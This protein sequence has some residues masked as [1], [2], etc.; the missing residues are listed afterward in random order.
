MTARILVVDDIAANLRLLEA[1]LAA[2]YYEVALAASGP[3]ALTMVNRWAPDVILLDVMMP[4]MDGYEVCRRLKATP[5]TSHIP[6]VMVTALVDAAERVRA[7]EA[8]ADDFLSKPVDDPTLFARLRALLRVKQVQDA[9]RLRAETA[10]ELGFEAASGPEPGVRG[11]TCLVLSSDQA[12]VDSVGRILGED[13]V[14]CTG[15]AALDQAWAALSGASF[16]LAVLGLSAEGTEMLRFASRLRA[17]ASTRDMPVLLVAEPS[18]RGLVL[19]GFDL[20]ANDHVLRPV[21]PN[22]LRARARNQIR[23][24][25]YQERLRAD[26]DRS[27]ELAVTDPLTGLRNRRYVVRHLEGVLRGGEAAVLM[28]DVDRF[29]SINDTHGHAAGDIALREVAERLKAHLRAADVVARYGGEEF[30]VV[31]AG[32]PAEYAGAV[33]ERLLNTLGQDSI[34]I[35]SLKLNITASIGLAVAPQGTSAA[36]ATA[37]ADFALYRAKAA[38]RNRVEMARPED[39]AIASDEIQ[40]G[41]TPAVD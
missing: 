3:E 17:H 4:G 16:D 6:V 36:V 2:E 41:T 29:K 37:A 31:L 20:G 32:A 26:L 14:V 33:A 24:K 40:V 28:L 18:Q 13:G 25:H 11:A 38:G 8:G 15:T 35:G 12:E 7:L 9:W 23:R 34:A 5:A 10:R 39:F 1:K 19:R 22:E 27:L 21:D 30:M